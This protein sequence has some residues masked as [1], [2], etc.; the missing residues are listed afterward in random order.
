MVRLSLSY[1][2]VEKD[3][4]DAPIAHRQR[5]RPTLRK[6]VYEH[7]EKFVLKSPLQSQTSFSKRTHFV[8][9]NCTFD[10]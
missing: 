9:Q 10:T 8:A 7:P 5:D 3:Y 4:C 2:K 6:T 1:I